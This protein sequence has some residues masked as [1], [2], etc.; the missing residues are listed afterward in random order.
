MAVMY[1]TKEEYKILRKFLN[2]GIIIAPEVAE[3]LTE[4]EKERLEKAAN[5]Y[6]FGGDP[7]CWIDV[8][9]TREHYF[10]QRTI[11]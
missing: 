6:G 3:T 1:P 10:I 11:K 4:E 8:V 9:L 2:D 5:D 7:D